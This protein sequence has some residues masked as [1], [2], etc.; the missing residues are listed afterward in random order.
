MV[1]A[2]GI[3]RGGGLNRQEGRRLGV[4]LSNELRLGWLLSTCCPRGGVACQL[5]FRPGSVRYATQMKGREGLKSS[6]LLAHLRELQL[7]DHQKIYWMEKVPL[8][9]SRNC[10]SVELGDWGID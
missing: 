8:R 1:V 10:G 3:P 2:I 4:Y 5:H 9:A 7:G 6:V